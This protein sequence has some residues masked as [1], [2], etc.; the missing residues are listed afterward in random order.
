MAEINLNGSIVANAG[1]VKLMAK[2]GLK[3]IDGKYVSAWGGIQSAGQ[4]FGQVILQFFTERFGRKVAM[5]IIW[6]VLVLVG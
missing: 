1:F 6:G 2:P 4:F 5:Y 3:V